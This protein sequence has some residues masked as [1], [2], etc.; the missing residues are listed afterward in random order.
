MRQQTTV[1][2]SG[3]LKGLMQT[4]HLGAIVALSFSLILSACGGGGGNTT[5]ISAEPGPDGV[6]PTLTKVTLAAVET[7]LQ[8]AELGDTVKVSFTASES[9]QKP[10]VTINGVE[11]DVEGQHNSWSGARTMT[12]DD[13][14]G[15]V[16][17][18]I[19]FSDVSGVA[20]D[21]VSASTMASNADGKAGEWASVEYC[22]D[23]SCVV[24]PVVESK[25]DFEDSTLT[26]NWKDIGTPNNDVVPGILSELMVDPAI[27]TNTIVKSSIEAGGQPW[28]GAYLVVG[29][30][31]A[32]DFSFFLSEADSVVTM[33]VK[34]DAAGTKVVLK[35]EDATNNA[36]NVVAQAYTSVADEWETLYFDFSDPIE[37]AI[38]PAVE[39]GALLIIWGGIT[40]GKAA[41]TWYWDDVKHGGIVMPD[42]V[43]VS[44]VEPS[45]FAEWGQFG[46]QDYNADTGAFTFPATAEGWAGWANLNTAIAP[47]SFPEGGKITFTA[48]LPAGGLDTTVKFKFEKDAH[49]NV[50]PSF[51]TDVVVV[52]GET[53]AE[54][55]VTF[56]ARPDGESYK[57]LLMYIVERDSPVIIKK[58][59][60]TATAPTTAAWG[61]FGGGIYSAETGAFTFP[62]GAE[63]W[64]GWANTNTAITPFAFPYGGKVTFKAALPSGGAN[65][66][67][68]FKFE[69]DAHPDVNPSFFTDT[70]VVNSETEATY[71]VTF[72]ARPTGEVYK[73]LLMYI[74]ERD[75]G[76]IIKDVTVTASTNPYATWGEFGGGTYTAETGAFT[77]PTGAQDWAGWANTNTAISPF[78]FPNGGTVTFK[79]ALPAG[80]ADTSVKFKFEKDAHPNVDPSFFTDPVVVTGETETAYE[81]TFA[82]RPD[83]E[84]YKGLLMYIVERD[85]GLIIKEVTVTASP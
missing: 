24:Y 46:G 59:K 70:V 25:L 69:K 41:A 35:L 75:Q 67:L 56:T 43:N 36:K 29:E 16:A 13:A 78:S 30:T 72:A 76:V 9:L 27:A 33:R 81:V 44:P 53:E 34:S 10:T 64:A 84:V 79:A 80:V 50:D 1:G 8:Y 61:E 77:F 11:V 66:A 4:N 74:V 65:T 15:I 45:E 63:D 2:M 31:T 19:S 42:G 71:E 62:T 7:G 5:D 21:S 48:A 37:G 57:G 12:A 26:Y 47:F 23:G 55:E 40:S 20:G 22:A 83:G 49:P 3:W 28:A 6:A 38:D 85:Q 39:Y 32:P 60:V 51:F 52:T 14:D 82:A 73:G 54:Y 17:F 68:K 58:V 18:N